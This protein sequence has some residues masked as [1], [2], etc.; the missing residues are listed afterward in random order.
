ML[1]DS[2]VKNQYYSNIQWRHSEQFSTA[3]PCLSVS[4]GAIAETYQ[5]EIDVLACYK[6]VL[7]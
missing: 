6:Y 2:R 3:Y 7:Q 5:S 4:V 1:L